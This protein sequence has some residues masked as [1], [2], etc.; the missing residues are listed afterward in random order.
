M[1]DTW[2]WFKK[3]LMN[4]LCK[5]EKRIERSCRLQRSGLYSLFTHCLS[6][7]WEAVVT[8]DLIGIKSDEK[9][10][11]KWREWFCIPAFSSSY[12]RQKKRWNISQYVLAIPWVSIL[13]KCIWGKIRL[14]LNPAVWHHLVARKG[15]AGRRS[16]S[17]HQKTWRRYRMQWMFVLLKLT[18][19]PLSILP[20]YLPK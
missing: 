1:K 20:K 10:N 5:G 2:A 13:I 16:V 12:S 8:G 7:E 6:Q 18:T 3:N 14:R 4:N 15:S 11:K 19:S 9:Y 17:F